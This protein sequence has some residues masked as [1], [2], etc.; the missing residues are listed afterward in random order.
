[1]TVIADCSKMIKMFENFKI[2][3]LQLAKSDLN[4]M[5][6]TRKAWLSNFGFVCHVTSLKSNGDHCI[7]KAKYLP[8]HLS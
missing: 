4:K 1:M 6:M 2:C 5:Y 3:V 8:Y 7:K